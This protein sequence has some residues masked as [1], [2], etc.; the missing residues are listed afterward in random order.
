MPEVTIN[1][2]SWCSFAA[3][4]LLM[5]KIYVQKAVQCNSRKV[6]KEAKVSTLNQIA[7]QGTTETANDEHTLI[8]T[9]ILFTWIR[10]TPVPSWIFSLESKREVTNHFAIA[11]LPLPAGPKSRI[12][13]CCTASS[14]TLAAPCLCSALGRILSI[15]PGN[16]RIRWGL[17]QWER[18][19]Q[20]RSYK[21]MD[22]CDG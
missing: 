1:T 20:G 5:S 19:N 2:A 18:R 12:V 21:S 7:K 17:G 11:D 16:N 6:Q 10:R 8:S 15:L 9:G 3:C 13:N 4:G 14:V 22:R